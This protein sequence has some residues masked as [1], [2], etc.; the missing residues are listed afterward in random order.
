VSA[1]SPSAALVVALILAVTAQAASG[2]PA[3]PSPKPWTWEDSHRVTRTRAELHQILEDHAL[4][5]GSKGKKGHRA[6]LTGAIMDGADLDHADLKDAILNDARLNRTHLNYAVL[7]EAKLKNAELLGADLAN[8]DLG[9][10]DLSGANL[11]E[12]QLCNANLGE[13]RLNGAEL[14]GADVSGAHFIEAHLTDADLSGM[15]LTDANFLL[16]D[17]RGARYE[18]KSNPA[19]VNIAGANNIEFLT[20]E[21]NPLA[22]MQLRNQLQNDGFRI[23]ERKITYALKWN[24][25]K[26]ADWGER[27]F[28]TIAFDWT[29]QYGMNPGRALLI[30]LW[31]F[32]VCS[33]IYGGFI[34]H[35][36][37]SGIYLIRP[38]PE[39][40][41][42]EPLRPRPIPRGSRW[43][44]P[45]RVIGREAGVA[46]YALY[47]S[48]MTAFSLGV[49]DINFGKWLHQFPRREFELKPKGWARPVAAVQAILSV[50]L[51]VLWV[52][53]YF[54]RPFN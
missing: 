28:N 52:L 50:G 2:Q 44:Y 21:D 26:R 33:V 54:G 19:S 37:E 11:Y 31:L 8:A 38:G 13:A 42:D 16:V 18:P 10:A 14:V 29:S 3:R 30:W 35:T 23:A 40:S 41:P 51:I 24:E 15:D 5:L 22:L 12:A 1:P 17:L 32:L 43:S 6:D 39:K 27:W 9:G 47:F 20:Y 4:W 34:H 7:N 48:L 46:L 36:G 45:F 25:T 49:W 53:T